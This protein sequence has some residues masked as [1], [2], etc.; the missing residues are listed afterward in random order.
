MERFSVS[1]NKAV[2]PGSH[3]VKANEHW[4]PVGREDLG[5]DSTAVF[6][7]Q[8]DLFKVACDFFLR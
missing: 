8:Q 3:S 2:F 4:R 5:T 6:L 7:L 1:A